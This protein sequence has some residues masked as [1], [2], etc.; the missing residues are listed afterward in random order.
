[1]RPNRRPTKGSQITCK[2]VHETKVNIVY[3]HP[4]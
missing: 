4:E 3:E 1:L 2:K